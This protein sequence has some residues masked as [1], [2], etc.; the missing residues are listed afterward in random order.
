MNSS[1]N[2]LLL[3][4]SALSSQ[5]QTLLSEEI[6]IISNAPKNVN[7]VT[8]PIQNHAD[9]PS[10][11]GPTSSVEN[12]VAKLNPE[13]VQE[14]KRK[15][16]SE[17]AVE[18]L[19]YVSTKTQEENI[20]RS[21]EHGARVLPSRPPHVNS[22]EQ[23]T[24]T[25]STATKGLS[26]QAL[27]ENCTGSTLESAMGRIQ[28]SVSSDEQGQID[29]ES[30]AR[31]RPCPSRGHNTQNHDLRNGRLDRGTN[32]RLSKS[33]GNG[34]LQPSGGCARRTPQDMIPEAQDS[35]LNT[36]LHMI[37]WKVKE[38]QDRASEG[39]ASERREMKHKLEH[40]RKTALAA[41]SELESMTR[42]NT[43]LKEDLCKYETRNVKYQKRLSGLQ[44]RMNEF[45]QLLNEE[46]EEKEKIKRM[47]EEVLLE[48]RSIL[49]EREAL[50]Q[51]SKA[52]T[53]KANFILERIRA[54][55]RMGDAQITELQTKCCI[56][57]EDLNENNILLELE[58]SRCIELEK[59]LDITTA[60][61]EQF[62]EALE[63]EHSAAIQ[64][65]V[66]KI[67]RTIESSSTLQAL[68]NAANKSLG[69]LQALR[70]INE[71]DPTWR[72]EIEQ[73]MQNLASEVSASLEKN[74]RSGRSFVLS[75]IPYRW[76]TLASS[77]IFISYP[78]TP[79]PACRFF[80][81]VD[82]KQCDDYRCR[83]SSKFDS[84]LQ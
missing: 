68:G 39:L 76:Y 14:R 31:L 29:H 56:L 33:K 42:I 65:S 84:E 62:E 75:S 7:V 25:S 11:C 66:D 23:A 53:E 16:P 6:N 58:R 49:D 81:K 28:S 67:C 19:D 20:K 50:Q 64:E 80:A 38:E 17:E 27:G 13:L 44:T 73:A 43:K 3:A 61:L 24:G 26:T 59:E 45:G 2:A 5:S 82:T 4:G 69:I 63:G 40:Y 18:D 48:G 70:Q 8:D 36:M 72:R 30:V 52:S 21:E 55:A 32:M 1:S 41:Q 60:R 15:R 47:H 35:S 74:S 37:A 9:I 79:M 51:F 77:R 34:K 46:Q 78:I 83:L 54:V 12:I 71:A 22:L 10:P 57:E